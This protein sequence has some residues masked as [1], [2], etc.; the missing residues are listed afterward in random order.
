MRHVDPHLT[1]GSLG[2]PESTVQTA[3][4]SVQPF[5]A[6]QD[7]DRTTDRQTDRATPSITIGRNFVVY[8]EMQP[9]NNTCSNRSRNIDEIYNVHV[10][11]STNF[12]NAPRTSKNRLHKF[13]AALASYADQVSRDRSVQAINILLFL[14]YTSYVST[15]AVAG[16]PSLQLRRLDHSKRF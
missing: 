10:Y 15:L 6:A 12:L 16:I 4:R 9:S 7:C 8:S 11:Q 2:P 1:H 3:S 14:A 13:Y 5:C